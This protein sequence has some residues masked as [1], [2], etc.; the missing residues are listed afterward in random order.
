MNATENRLELFSLGTLVVLS[1]FTQAYEAAALSTWL[2]DGAG[3]VAIV[4]AVLLGLSAVLRRRTKRT[5]Q[6]LWENGKL[7]IR[8]RPTHQLR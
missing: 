7:A 1:V 3:V 8:S 2:V 5:L 6:A 4:V